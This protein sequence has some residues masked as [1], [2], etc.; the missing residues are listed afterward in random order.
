MGPPSD[1]TP[2]VQATKTDPQICAPRQDFAWVPLQN[3]LQ[4]HESH[5]GKWYQRLFITCSNRGARTAPHSFIP[6]M[7]LVWDIPGPGISHIWSPALPH[8]ISNSWIPDSPPN[9]TSQCSVEA[10]VEYSSARCTLTGGRGSIRHTPSHC[11]AINR[12]DITIH[13]R[14]GQVGSRPTYRVLLLVADHHQARRHAVKSLARPGFDFLSFNQ[15][16]NPNWQNTRPEE[17]DKVTKTG[18][19]LGRNNN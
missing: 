6:T 11:T 1:L 4:N 14:S 17:D 10:D 2:H 15:K 5:L 8:K 3:V 7:S 9:W 12:A 16:S 13:L 19:R 18:L